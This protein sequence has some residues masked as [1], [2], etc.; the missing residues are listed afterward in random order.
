MR[1]A[2][3]TI[4]DRIR[5]MLSVKVCVKEWFIQRFTWTREQQIVIRYHINQVLGR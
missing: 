4:K 2:A 1:P 5:Y 3:L